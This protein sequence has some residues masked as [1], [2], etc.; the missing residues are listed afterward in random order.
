VDKRS[1]STIS[2]AAGMLSAT[3]TELWNCCHGATH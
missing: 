2:L 1:A 3:A